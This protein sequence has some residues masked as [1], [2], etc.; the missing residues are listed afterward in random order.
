MHYVVLE[1]QVVHL[2]DTPKDQCR[3]ANIAYQIVNAETLVC[4]YETSSLPNIEVNGEAKSLESAMVQLDKDIHDIIGNDEFVLVSLRSTWHIRV[5]L[6]RQARDD[7]FILTSYLQHPKVFDLWKEFDR[8][9]VNHP[10]ILG[11]KKTISNNNCNAK[12]NSASVAKNTKDLDEMVRILEVSTPNEDAGSVPQKYSLLKKTTEILIQLHKKCSSPEDMKSVLT[13]P[14]DSHTDIRTFLQERSK[15][16]YMNNLPPD[17]TQSELES[18]FTQYG[19]RPVGFWT[20][21]NIVEDTSNVNNNWSLNNSPYVEDQDS[22]S[23]FVVFQTH[24][25]ATEVLALNGR[26]ILSNLANTKQPR[27]VEHVLELQPSSTGVLD[28]AQEILSP[29]PQSKNKPRPGDWNCPSC[30]FSNFQRRTACFRCSFPAPSNIQMHAVISNN[31]ANGSRNNLNNRVNSGSSNNINNTALN[32]PYSAPEFNMVANTTPTALTYN[33]THFPAIT[34]LSRQNSLNLAPSNSGSPIIIADH[35]SGNNNMVP[36]YRYNN[37]INNNNNNINN[38]TNNRYNSNNNINGNENG[39]GNNINNNNNH[40]NNHHNG[41]NNNNTN[42]NNNN[43]CNSNVGMGGCG[44]NIPFRAGDWKC[45]TCTYHNFA[46]NVVCLR[47]GGPKSINA[48]ANETNHYIDASTI[49]PASRAPSNNNISVNNNGGNNT[50]RTDGNDNK[51][52]DISLME[53]MSP[54]LSM[55]KSTKEGDG[56]GSSFNELKSDKTNVNFSNDGNSSAFGNG[57]NSSVRW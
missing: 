6:P 2:P 37:N 1:L 13:Q 31:N 45:S 57:F 17:T 23:G 47:C 30:G 52:R 49:G 55:V 11:Q 26:S 3:I 54:P 16:L 38:M 22:I 56:N 14:Y 18:W 25:E 12:G 20:V 10:E 36:N 48:D 9:C 34:P 40:N 53:F 44:S 7:G 46:K 28:K 15:I 27:V 5:T 4:H 32:H 43:N 39:N 19:V 29:F 24:E 35:F 8:W 21:K 41:S 50:D 42:T 51:G 33:R